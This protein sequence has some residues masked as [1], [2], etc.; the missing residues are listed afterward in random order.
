MKIKALTGAGISRASNIPTFEEMGDL[1]DKLSRTY[2]SADPQ[3]FYDAVLSMKTLIDEAVPNEAHL[4]LASYHIPVVTMN[5]DGLHH[6]AGSRDGEVIEIHGNLRTVFCPRCH[7]EYPFDITRSSL[8]CPHCERSVLHPQV[9]LYG[10]PIPRLGEAL[11]TMG[12]TDLLLIIGTSFYT[13]TAHYIKDAAES[14]GSEILTINEDAE[15]QVPLLLKK[16][17]EGAN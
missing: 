15:N 13:S 11:E 5:I 2:F 9:V 14:F 1:R 4:A 7:R 3:G 16:L 12:E 17:L 6:R 10:D 8:L